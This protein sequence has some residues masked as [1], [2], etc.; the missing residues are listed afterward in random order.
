MFHILVLFFELFETLVITWIPY[1]PE[2]TETT[3]SIFSKCLKMSNQYVQDM[4][5][6]LLLVL[7]FT[8]MLDILVLDPDLYLQI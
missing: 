6:H 8:A 1:I 7:A 5:Y 4:S 2:I 3:Y